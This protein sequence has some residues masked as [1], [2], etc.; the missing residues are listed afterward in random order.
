MTSTLRSDAEPSSQQ[1]ASQSTG[2][3]Q[4]RRARARAA[5]HTLTR[6]LAR[7]HQARR[8]WWSSRTVAFRKVTR[9]LVLLAV[10]AVL[11]VAIGLVTASASSPIGPHT[12]RWST[13]LDSQITL[14]L[15]PLGQASLDSPAGVIGVEVVL[16]EIP[17]E[18]TSTQ[19]DASTLGQ[20]LS[21][22]AS[23]YVSLVSHPDLTVKAGLRALLADAVRRAGLV[24]SLVLCLVAVGRLA[25]SGRLRDSLLASMRHGMATGLAAVT[26]VGTVLALLVPALGT[27]TSTG[28][29]LSVLAGTPLEGAR[30]SGRLA[31][32]VQAYGP[33]VREVIDDNEAFYAKAGANMTAAWQASQEVDGLVDVTVADAAVDTQALRAQADALVAKQ[34]DD[35][36]SPQPGASELTGGKA[37]ETATAQATQAPLVTGG[38]AVREHVATTA[39]LSTDLHC[40]LDMITLAGQLDRLAGAQVHL[41][42][43][44]LTMTGSN[45]EQLCVDALTSAVPR[46]V[47]RVAT[48]G[49]HD[50]DETGQQLRSRGWTVTDGTVQEV[51][52]LRVLGDVDANRTPAGRNY[53]RGQENSEQIGQR[54]AEVSC[55]PGS[56]VDLVLI[57]QPYTFSP[58]ISSGCAPLLV[59]GHSHQEYGMSV[60]EGAQGPVAQLRAGAG[61]GGTS[62]GKLK[63]DAYLHVLAFDEEGRLLGWRAVTIHTDASVTVGAW[64]EVPPVGTSWQGASQ[65]A[66]EIVSGD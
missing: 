54:L 28:T 34:L 66:L 13:T 44:D 61:L 58:L 10:T 59:A 20:T 56:D 2:A 53:Q 22:D 37:Q 16:G 65:A 30:L 55:E 8:R 41:D 24:A 4:D 47:A 7:A 1:P 35:L 27:H 19:V 26:A 14:D 64:N 29:T 25:T 45:P 51:G 57:H 5:V 18:S 50:S 23:S 12:A 42:D 3:H 43:G 15:G 49:N 52:G 32:V 17:A 40:N 31:D 63:S 38:L 9:T 60:S 21:T 33:K 62:V 36:P 46:G 11:S 39:V 48:I 6:P